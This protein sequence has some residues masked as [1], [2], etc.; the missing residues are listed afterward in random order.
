VKIG[1]LGFMEDYGKPKGDG[2]WVDGN[3]PGLAK[4]KKSHVLKAMEKMRPKVHIMI[5]NFHWGRN[6]K[7]TTEKGGF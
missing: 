3:Q 5:V 2:Y 1:F 7:K 4:M 6:Y